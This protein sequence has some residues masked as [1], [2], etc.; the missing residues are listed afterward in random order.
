MCLGRTSWQEEYVAGDSLYLMV[1]RKQRSGEGRKGGREEGR[2]EGR[3]PGRKEGRK[4]NAGSIT[5][6][7]FKLHYRATVTKNS[8]AQKQT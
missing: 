7:D 8:T 4:D 5:I 2:K 3:K 6:P 1:D